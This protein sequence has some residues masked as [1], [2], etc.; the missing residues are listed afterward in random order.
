MFKTWRAFLV[1]VLGAQHAAEGALLAGDSLLLDNP[2][3]V[4]RFEGQTAEHCQRTELVKRKL[5]ALPSIRRE[6]YKTTKNGFR[7][8]A[9]QEHQVMLAKSCFHPKRGG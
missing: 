1:P 5:A 2:S 9:G 4:F 6:K 3:H 8:L 7:K